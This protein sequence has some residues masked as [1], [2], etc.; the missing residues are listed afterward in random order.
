ML[1]N[2]EFLAGINNSYV[3]VTK[4]DVIYE[5]KFKP[6]TYIVDIENQDENSIFEFVIEVLF[7]PNNVALTLDK[8]LAPTI[9]QIFKDFYNLNN[10]SVTIYICDSSDGKQF[11][12]KRKF[13]YW[14]SE[15]NDNTFVKFDD[16]LLDN[17]RNNFPISFILKKNNPNFL[18]ILNN[19]LNFISENNNDK[20]N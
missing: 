19:F 9:N 13:D 11:I 4:S 5:I 17:E 3:I 16:V 6:S 7:K 10:D 15:F 2:Y 14:F 12:R 20:S 1:Y 18:K 8:F